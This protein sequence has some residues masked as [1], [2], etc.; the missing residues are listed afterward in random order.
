MAKTRKPCPSCGIV[1][2]WGREVDQICNICQNDRK[3]LA[4]LEN[5]FAK[6]NSETVMVYYNA[7]SHWN[8]YFHTH[9]QGSDATVLQEAFYELAEAMGIPYTGESTKGEIALLGK[10]TG[11]G[12]SMGKRGLLR[13]DIAE[14]FVKLHQS[15][16]PVLDAVHEASFAQGDNLLMR[17]ANGDLAPNDYLQKKNR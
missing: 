4:Y 13:R 10:G 12:F 6:I 2:P 8:Q 3:R 7:A 9:A 15:I 5:E 11:G 1:R 16:Q 17:L 14:A